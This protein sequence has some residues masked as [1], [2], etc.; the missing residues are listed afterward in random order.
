MLLNQNKL[1]EVASGMARGWES[2]GW[3]LLGD[4]I[5]T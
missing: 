1:S 3:P 4:M 2:P 5:D